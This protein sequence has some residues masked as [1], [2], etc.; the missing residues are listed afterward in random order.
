VRCQ[1]HPRRSRQDLYRGAY[2][3]ARILFPIAHGLGLGA[4]GAMSAA[5]REAMQV[6]RGRA[7]GA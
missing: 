7:H 1:D 6:L 5:T 3:P 4:N 2:P